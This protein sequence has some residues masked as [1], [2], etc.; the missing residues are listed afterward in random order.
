MKFENLPKAFDK[1][2]IKIEEQ[3]MD[4]LLFAGKQ[5]QEILLDR[6]FD[7]TKTADGENFGGYR[8]ES[9]KKKRI[10]AARQVS[11]K[12][13]DVTGDFRK[14]IKLKKSKNNVTLEFANSKAIMIAEG[15]ERQIGQILAGKAKVNMKSTQKAIIFKLSKK[16]ADEVIKRTVA[17]LKRNLM[18]I[19]KESFR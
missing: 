19:V 5:A 7:D 16:E 13:L 9:Y 11:Q 18:K 4:L 3:E 2:I 8:S 12:D 6:V 14:A 1:L 17:E 10:R 15:Q